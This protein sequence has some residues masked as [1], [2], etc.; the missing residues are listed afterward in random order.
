MRNLRET[1]SIAFPK[2]STNNQNRFRRSKKE[3][4]KYRQRV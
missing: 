1:V 3:S 4:E 2:S